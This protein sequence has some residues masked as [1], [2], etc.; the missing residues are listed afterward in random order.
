MRRL[1]VLIIGIL[2]IAGLCIPVWG[3]NY[4]SKIQI[5]ANVNTNESCQVT[6]VATLHVEENNGQLSFPVPEKATGVSL[7][8]SRV[9]THRG[10][11]CQYIDISDVVG[12]MT[13]DFTITVTYSLPDVIEYTEADTPELQ[14][15]MLA[16]YEGTVSRLDFTVSL[17]GEIKAKPAFSSGYHL[18]GIEE[19][20]SCS[21]NGTS[22]V[23]FA[24]AELKDHETLTM[25]LDVDPSLFP[26]SPL[27][28]TDTSV[29]DIAMII[30]GVLALLYW[31][32]FLRS[33]PGFWKRSTTAPEG[34]TA[35]EVGAVM[36]LGKADLS[37]MVF[38]WAQLGYIQMQISPKRVILHKRMDMGNERSSFEQ[39]CFHRLF[40][41]RDTVDTGSLHYALLCRAVEKLHPPI[42]SLVHSGSGN[43]KIF[44][45]LAALIGLFGGASFGIA[46][47]QEAAAQWLGVFSMAALGFVCSW[48]MQ[49]LMGEIFQR[50]SSKTVLSL[51]FT[52]VHLLFGI[53]AGQFGLAFG[54]MLIQWIVG[55]MAYFGGRRTDAGK[56]DFSRVM[57]LRRY[58]TSVSKEELSRIEETDPEYFHTLAPF[59]LAL[60]VNRSFAHRFGKGH[61][62][63]CPYIDHRSGKAHTAREWS[64]LMEQALKDMNRRSRMLPIERFMAIF[65]SAKK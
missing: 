54:L 36:T 57:G 60:G 1:T 37:L 17:P 20:I 62:S 29:D 26:R 30:C 14:L 11:Q 22:V 25:Y 27:V 48:C 40:K 13:G 64:D 2:L 39:L 4:A 44:R 53:I 61:F 12:T 51:V 55:I 56:Q 46:M 10:Q 49:A 63:E 8:G 58:L 34:L 16:G 19:D 3:A 15:A 24:T 28:F 42:H 31:I 32:I 59:A 45:L 18:T 33:L 41:K 23:G 7:N 50:K 9:R 35:G 38:S 5:T 43:S 47:T 6:V 52:G 65:S 21:V